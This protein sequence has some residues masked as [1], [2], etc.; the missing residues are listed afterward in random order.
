[1]KTTSFYC[2]NAILG[3]IYQWHITLGSYWHPVFLF[4]VLCRR[5]HLTITFSVIKQNVKQRFKPCKFNKNKQLL[6]IQ[7]TN[8]MK[9][10]WEQNIP[11]LKM[12][13]LYWEKFPL[14]LVDWL[15]GPTLA[16]VL[17]FY[18]AEAEYCSQVTFNKATSSSSVRKGMGG[19]KKWNK[20]TIQCWVDRGLRPP[21][22]THTRKLY[23]VDS[24]H[25]LQSTSYI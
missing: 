5:C 14:T 1:M 2:S 4:S 24:I 10:F 8:L 15:F 19:I 13:A 22:S 20:P 21:C 6:Y 18:M 16:W 25:S 17:C 12:T 9:L 11:L 7:Y 23:S 3:V